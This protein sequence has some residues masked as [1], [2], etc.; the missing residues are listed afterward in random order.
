[1]IAPKVDKPTARN[2]K[3]A[4]ALATERDGDRCV[5]CGDNEWTERDHRKGRGVGGLTV[6]WNIH[7]LCH[8]HHLQKTDNAEWALRVGLTVPSYGDP[9]EWPSRRLVN[10]ELRWVIYG[11]GTDFAIIPDA[12]AETYLEIKGVR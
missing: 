4:Y 5:W 2:Q 3:D 6:E 8:T 1:M 10:D 12:T 7:V 11:A 9:T